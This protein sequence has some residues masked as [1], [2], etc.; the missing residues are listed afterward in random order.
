M[1]DSLFSLLSRFPAMRPIKTLTILQILPLL[2]KYFGVSIT[3]ATLYSY[4]KN[5]GFPKSMGIGKPRQWRK[6]RVMTWI[7]QQVRSSA[8]PKRRTIK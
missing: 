3:R 1:L 8:A 6:D 5:R 2:K 4:I 7:Y